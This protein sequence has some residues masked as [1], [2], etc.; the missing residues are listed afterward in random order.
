MIHYD[1]LYKILFQGITDA[2]YSIKEQD[3]SFA[4]YLLI[5]AQQDSE[6]KYIQSSNE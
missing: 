5:K 1:E 6:E 4:L 3:Y 2:I